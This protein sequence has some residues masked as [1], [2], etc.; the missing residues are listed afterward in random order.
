MPRSSVET[1]GADVVCT[2]VGL[3]VVTG[4][5]AVGLFVVVLTVVFSVCFTVVFLVEFVGLFG[6]EAESDD[7]TVDAMPVMI[8]ITVISSC[9]AETVSVC[10]YVYE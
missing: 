6:F 9:V 3:T 2:V 5:V 8:F 4:F 7:A 10:G 1:E